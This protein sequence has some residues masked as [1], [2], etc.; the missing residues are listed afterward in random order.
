N[1][2]RPDM[3]RGSNEDSTA[4]TPAGRAGHDAKPELYVGSSV[5][6]RWQQEIGDAARAVLI[7][8]YVTSPC[9]ADVLLAAAGRVE[10]YT[11]FSARNFASGAS[12]LDALAELLEKGVE[13]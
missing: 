9:A 11:V 6:P 10:L 5:A 4:M 2:P 12:S 3:C 7:S 8:P 13:V 1:S